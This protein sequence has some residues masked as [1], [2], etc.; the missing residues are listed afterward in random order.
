MDAS[1]VA[2]VSKHREEGED[3]T[4][5][6]LSGFAV[7]HKASSGTPT[8]LIRGQE[9]DAAANM[10]DQG[11]Y[12]IAI[13]TS[14]FADFEYDYTA[15][16]EAIT[17]TPENVAD[18][19][20]YTPTYHG[21]HVVMSSCVIDPV[22]TYEQIEGGN[23]IETSQYLNL[24]DVSNEMGPQYDGTTDETLCHWIDAP[25]MSPAEVDWHLRVDSTSSATDVSHRWLIVFNL[26]AD[27]GHIEHGYIQENN[28]F[29]NSSVSDV[30]MLR[31]AGGQFEGSGKYLILASSLFYG[32]DNTY[33]YQNGITIGSTRNNDSYYTYE[34]PNT[35]D[36]APYFFMDVLT[37][38]ATPEQ[39]LFWHRRVPISSSGSC[40]TWAP[41]LMWIRLDDDLTEDTDWFYTWSGADQ[42]HSTTF[43]SRGTLQFTPSEAGDD[44]LILASMQIG[45]DTTAFSWE[46]RVLKDDTTDMVKTTR[47]GE[48]INE[49]HQVLMW[50]VDEALPASEVTYKLQTR[51][52]TGANNDHLSSR[53]FAINLSKLSRTFEHNATDADFT[54]TDSF[55]ES[56]R[57]G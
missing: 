26:A 53:F 55:S 52:E 8:P 21:R 38:A 37:Q 16:Q 45:I 24:G 42:A 31:A 9:T 36:A 35:G 12:M 27:D 39:I 20:N 48:D 14:V 56:Q 47:E 7:R 57:G 5:E 17:S 2:T 15:A 28:F 50:F 3:V 51:D 41:A 32:T 19:L 33:R 54:L 25:F 34:Q 29:S 10:T 30:T 6:R 18:I 43:T 22:T 11:A 44:W 46:G 13:P 49:T 23:A 40:T 4:E 1:T